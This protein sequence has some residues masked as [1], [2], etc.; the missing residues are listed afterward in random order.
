MIEE[1]SK[2]EYIRR[3]KKVYSRYL[4]VICLLQILGIFINMVLVIGVIFAIKIEN[5]DTNNG[6]DDIVL[7]TQKMVHNTYHLCNYHSNDT[8]HNCIL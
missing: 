4:K 5:A 8:D 6:I 1:E 7:F 3:R 2:I